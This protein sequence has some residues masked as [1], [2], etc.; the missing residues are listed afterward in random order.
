MY[1]KT[2]FD[3]STMTTTE[4]TFASEEYFR[5]LGDRPELAEAFALGE[6][7]IALSGGEAYEVVP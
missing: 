7:V 5:L 6:R 1:I 3:P 2:T 4:M